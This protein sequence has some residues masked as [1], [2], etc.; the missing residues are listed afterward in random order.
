[1]LTPYQRKGFALARGFVV[2]VMPAIHTV[3]LYSTFAV[4]RGPIGAVLGFLAETSGA[5][6]FMLL[7]GMFIALGR[8]KT[9]AY[10][11]KRMLILLLA[12]YLLNVFKLLMPYYWGWIPPQFLSDN[13]VTE[14]VAMHLFLTGDI[15]Q[16]AA[17]AYACCALIKKGIRNVVGFAIIFLIV[18]LIMPLTWSIRE[19]GLLTIP[20]ALLNGKPPYTFFPLFPWLLYPLAGLIVGTLLLKLEHLRFNK[21]LLLLVPGLML[22]GY[23]LSLTEPVGWQAEFYRLGRGRTLFHIGLA[24]GWSLLFIWL[25][26]KIRG[27]YLFH[28]LQWLSD[29]I[30]LAYILQW[31]VIFWCF[32]LFGYNQLKTIPSLLALCMTTTTSFLILAAVLAGIKKIKS[33]NHGR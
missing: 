11:L 14:R 10:I 26:K 4:K 29:N 30:M 18:L 27:N 25:A 32:P 13:G 9:S 2:L 31:I 17:I 21:L 23:L 16:F 3:L 7:M 5:P 20:L 15:L 28:L 6:L 8:D 33:V 24:L 22:M 19:A 12:G 1:M